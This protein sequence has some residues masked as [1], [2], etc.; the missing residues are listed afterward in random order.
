MNYLDIFISA[1]VLFGMV[2]GFM[3]GLLVELA[4]LLGLVF[5]VYGAIHFSYFV[6]DFLNAKMNWSDQTTHWVAFGITFVLIVVAVALLGKILTKVASTVFLNL[7]NKIAGAVF[8][9]AKMILI[10]GIALNYFI[11]INNTFA[12]I[13]KKHIQ[14]S[15]FLLWVKRTPHSVLPFFN[16]IF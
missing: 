4:G 12:I 13:D 5:G 7:P 1:V 3:K 6:G 14:E 16:Q 8:G 10:L 11:S 9:G 15:L 2:R